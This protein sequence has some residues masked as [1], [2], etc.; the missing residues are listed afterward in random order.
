MTNFKKI[1]PVLIG[2]NYLCFGCGNRTSSSSNNRSD[3]K[4][5]VTFSAKLN[6]EINGDSKIDDNYL[7]I[8]GKYYGCFGKIDNSEWNLSKNGGNLIFLK[9]DKNCKIKFSKIEIKNDQ[10]VENYIIQGESD[11][12]GESYQDKPI[13]FAFSTEKKFYVL[14]KISPLDLSREPTIS[15]S[16]FENNRNKNDL[17]EKLIVQEDS[18]NI[19]VPSIKFINILQPDYTL[20]ENKSRLIK[21]SSNYVL[22]TGNFIFES[23]KTP[24]KFYFVVPGNEDVSNEERVND[25]INSA[26]EKNSIK[27]ISSE[28][29]KK[30]VEISLAYI[31]NYANLPNKIEKNDKLN[32]KIIFVNEHEAPIGYVCQIFNLSLLVE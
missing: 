29:G 9:D 20:K 3:I 14:A 25:L 11:F 12:I 18:T 5:S 17:N 26:K 23:I 2:A 7:N 31:A 1:I 13:E 10:L 16:I 32:A 15:V 27:M 24:S 8:T 28:I 19:M 4:E 30:D 22:Y 6:K 21:N